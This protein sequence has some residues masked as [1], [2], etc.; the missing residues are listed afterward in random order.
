M[1]SKKH[2]NVVPQRE[3][4]LRVPKA[5]PQPPSGD[6]PFAKRRDELKGLTEAQIVLLVMESAGWDA[7]KPFLEEV[8]QERLARRKDGRGGY[9]AYSA[10]DIEK[11]LLFQRVSGFRTYKKAHERLCGADKEP[12][13]TLGFTHANR[14]KATRYLDGVPSRSTI[15]RHLR[16]FGK[17]RRGDAWDSLAR[18]LRDL[19][20]EEF[21]ELRAEAQVIQT[22]GTKIETHYTAP[23]IDRKTKTVVNSSH[24]TAPDAGYVPPS[25]G[26]DKSGHGWTLMPIS[27][28]QG[29]PLSWTIS[30]LHASESVTATSLVLDDF[31]QNVIPRL[32]QNRGVG[33]LTA[34]GAFS[35]ARLREALRENGYV[36]NIHH[37][38]HKTDSSDRA[39]TERK[40]RI[41]IEGYMNWFSDGHRQ[42]VCTCGKGSTSG[43]FAKTKSG[44]VTTRVEGVCANCGSI[45]ITSG[46]WTL[47]QNPPRFATIDSSNPDEDPD[48]LLGNPLTFDNPLSGEF[49]RRRMG[50]CEGLYGTF[51][52]RWKLNKGKR[53]LRSIH[54]VR[55][56]VGMVFSIIHVLTME[57]R[58][59]KALAPPGAPLPLAA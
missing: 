22:D 33:I 19:H 9:A 3:R 2:L 41:P 54:D 6:Q 27:T 28:A 25:A 48:Y 13:E 15:S 52:T 31:R 34:D 29:V 45:T 56:D 37:V 30:P 18:A 20:L 58:R 53:W 11:A 32:D 7:I 24:V 51:A 46:L 12:R 14:K 5:L 49:G 8:D 50:H 55:A 47:A 36:E 57:Q 39:A 17:E 26:P 4:R 1:A 21:P 38:S 10:E 16:R 40:R 44:R 42:L 23:K 59:L 43:R 35:S